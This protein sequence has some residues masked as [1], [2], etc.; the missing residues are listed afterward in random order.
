MIGV[1][2]TK[3]VLLSGVVA[4]GQPSNWSSAGT[5]F[6]YRWSR[7]AQNSCQ[8]EVRSISS[9]AGS[10]LSLDASYLSHAAL[11]SSAQQLKQTVQLPKGSSFVQSIAECEKVTGVT[12]VAVE[13]NEISKF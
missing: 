12:V 1:T 3:L 4:G 10:M 8:L 5:S 6:E 13:K 7:P 9:A 11:K 2:F